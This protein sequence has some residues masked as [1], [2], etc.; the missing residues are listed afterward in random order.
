VFTTLIEYL[1]AL[2]AR[3]MQGNAIILS[4]F[5]FFI[6]FKIC[7]TLQGGCGRGI[8]VQFIA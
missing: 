8:V 5:M 4:L 2:M 1:S 3:C 7:T 6:S